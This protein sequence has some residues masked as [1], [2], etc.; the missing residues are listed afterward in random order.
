MVCGGA[1]RGEGDMEEARGR[2]TQVHGGGGGIF[3]EGEMRERDE[4]IDI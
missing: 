2:K 3:I 4:C 1:N